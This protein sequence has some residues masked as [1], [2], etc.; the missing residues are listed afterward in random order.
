[1]CVLFVSSD[2]YSNLKLIVDVLHQCKSKP[3][4]FSVH[5][6]VNILG[7]AP[8]F[9]AEKQLKCLPAEPITCQP[10]SLLG[11]KKQKKKKTLHFSPST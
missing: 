3:T 6:H 1:M 11:K 10:A 4:F 2:F 7:T 5:A 8:S 9:L